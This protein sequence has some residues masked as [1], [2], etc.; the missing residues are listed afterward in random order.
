MKLFK[1]AVITPKKTGFTI[2]ELLV[3][4]GI[5]VLFSSILISYNHTSRQQ[6]ALYAEETK[7]IQAIFR[8]KSL[9]LGSYV[10]PSTP[11]VCG[12]GVHFDYAAMKY[13]IFSYNKAG[14]ANCQNINEINAGSQD[15]ISTFVLGGNVKLVG[16]PQGG[17]RLD[18][19]L[20]V[21]PDPITLVN[22]GGT[23]IKNGSAVI[24]LQTIDGSLSV[25]IN[26]NSAGLIDF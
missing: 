5:A 15:A 9:A 8:A 20:F 21:P 17:S 2:I 16:L 13:Y 7:L 18:D 6:L 23:I 22:S 25:K 19:V 24:Y 1:R 26:I 3:A 12:Y 10:K 14:I 11:T 4:L